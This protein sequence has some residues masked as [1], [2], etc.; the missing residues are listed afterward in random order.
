MPGARHLRDFARALGSKATRKKRQLEFLGLDV[1]T[2]R[3]GVAVTHE[4]S[5]VSPVGVLM[6]QRPGPAFESHREEVGDVLVV[7]RELDAAVLLSTTQW[8]T[9]A[10]QVFSLAA[11]HSAVG[12]VVG[13]PLELDGSE[14]RQCELVRDYLW[15]LFSEAGEKP[16]TTPA[17]KLEG[18]GGRE[19]GREMEGGRGG[20]GGR[21]RGRGGEGGREGTREEEDRPPRPTRCAWIK[22]EPSSSHHYRDGL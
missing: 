7:S 14:G 19:G 20:E 16:G 13:W 12:L 1:G 11:R 5:H 3:V 21:E 9:V 15:S 17:G 4:R 8:S 2:K 6:R 18:E 10:S 22:T